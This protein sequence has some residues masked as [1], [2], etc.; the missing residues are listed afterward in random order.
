[1]H[2]SAAHRML[3]CP[4]CVCCPA[5]CTASHTLHAIQ[6]MQFNRGCLR[7]SIQHLMLVTTQTVCCMLAM[8]A[9]HSVLR[10]Y[11]LCCKPRTASNALS[12]CVR[13]AVCETACCAA[14]ALTQLLCCNHLMRGYSCVSIQQCISS[15]QSNQP[16]RTK[17]TTARLNMHRLNSILDL[18]H[19]TLQDC[20]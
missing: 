17:L 4:I 15:Q 6:H 12:I 5:L 9:N 1:M 11:L 14:I 10:A 7:V 8:T 13:C 3:P 19:Q 16:C 18:P 20:N 2:T